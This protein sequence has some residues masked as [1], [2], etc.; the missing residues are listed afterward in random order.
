MDTKQPQVWLSDK[1]L[2]DCAGSP[3]IAPSQRTGPPANGEEQ[4]MACS[5]LGRGAA[6]L[7]D[8]APGRGPNTSV[9]GSVLVIEPR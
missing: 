5:S 9:D 1:I 7:Q 4:A 6:R 8:V 2:T 3:F